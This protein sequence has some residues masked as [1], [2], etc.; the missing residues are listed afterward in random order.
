[1]ELAELRKLVAEVQQRRME[2]DAIEV[3][4]AHKG[5]PKVYDSLSSFANRSGGGVILLGLDEAQ[6]F[7]IVGVGDLQRAQADVSSWARDEMEPPAF[8][9]RRSSFQVTFHNHM[10]MNP[11]AIAWLGQFAA[12]PLND[13]QRLALV[14]L[15]QHQVISN[16]AY[17]RLN[18]VDPMIA[19]HELRGLVE[20]DLAEQQGVG[21]WTS[22]RLEVSPEL[23]GAAKPRTAKDRVVAYVREHGSITNAQCRELLEVEEYQAYYM[24][25]KLCDGGMLQP[26]GKG[27]GRKYVLR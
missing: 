25:K 9:D 4:T 6:D 17:R 11:D 8:D 27:K 10:L 13:R 2:P 22:Y 5:T 19:G 7:K 24:L 1:M 15:R 26:A 3:K 18:R 21:R 20:A 12:K 16:A 23:S 14:Y